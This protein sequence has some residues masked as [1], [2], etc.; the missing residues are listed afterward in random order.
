MK[1]L[2]I[3]T[4]L[5]ALLL[6][7]CATG[8]KPIVTPADNTETGVNAE[9]ETNADTETNTES[10]TTPAIVTTDDSWRDAMNA[11]PFDYVANDLTPYVKLGQ[12]KGL[13]VPRES[14]VITEEEYAQELDNLLNQY[15]DCNHITDRAVEVGDTTSTNYMGFLNGEQMEGG[16]AE[17]AEVVAADGTG[18]IDGFGTALVGHMPGEEFSFDVTFP[19]DYGNESLQGA[20]VTFVCTVNYIYGGEV[21]V[22][23]LT[24]EFV[25][26]NFDFSSVAEFETTFRDYIQK[27][28]SYNVEQSMYAALWQMILDNAEVIEYPGVEVNRVYALNRDYYEKTAESYQLD[29]ETFLTNYARTTEEEMIEASKVYVKEDLVMNA[30]LK[31]LNISYTEEEYQQ[32]VEKIAES[33]G[34]TADMLKQY[35]GDESLDA[36]VKWQKVVESILLESN[37]VPAE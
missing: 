36:T 26:E 30:L 17:N 12:Y 22:P 21:I 5:A 27:E 35:Y 29:Y 10:E 13:T 3:F 11:E 16:T 9:N 7:S 23:E 14:D 24:E 25:T 18:Y 34:T 32:E 15:A 6:T 1:K 8:T 28:K 19:E 4:L 33:L 2:L 20:N 37:I 31:E